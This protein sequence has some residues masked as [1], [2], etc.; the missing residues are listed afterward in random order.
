MCGQVQVTFLNDKNFSLP[1]SE[2]AFKLSF[3]REAINY[4]N[5]I[6]YS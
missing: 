4:G 5:K 6:E 3:G 1:T 2:T